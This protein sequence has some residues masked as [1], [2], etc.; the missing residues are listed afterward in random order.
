MRL[1]EFVANSQEVKARGK[2][3]QIGFE[4][5]FRTPELVKMD[6]SKS[7]WL[8]LFNQFADSPIEKFRD[9]LKNL[10]ANKGNTPRVETQ[11]NSKKKS[12]KTEQDSGDGDDSAGA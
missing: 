6:L 3:L 8:D 5:C 12:A 10:I 4:Q 11:S 7:Q 9:E 2:Y 1:N